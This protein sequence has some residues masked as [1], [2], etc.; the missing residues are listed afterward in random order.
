MTPEISII[1]PIYNV[2]QYLSHCLES[3]W[4]QSYQNFE[5]IMV[6]DGSSD[7]S[8]SIAQG[9]VD[10]DPGFRLV[11]QENK[12]LSAARNTGLQ[13]AKG[14][15]IFYLDADDYLR[16]NALHLL[17]EAAE[18]N[19]ADVVQGNFYYDYPEYLLLN[20]QQ[21]EKEI[22]YNRQE[23]MSALLEHKT[24]L[25]FAWGKLIRAPLAKQFP[26]PEGKYYEDTLWQSQV[27]HHCDKYVALNEPILYYLQRPSAISGSFSIRNLDQL[28]G[29]IER[30]ELLQQ[31]YPESYVY[32]AL[33]LLNRKVVQQRTLLKKLPPTA[34]QKYQKKL[35]EIEKKFDL[36]KRFPLSYNS[37]F[38]KGEKIKTVLRNKFLVTKDWE[39]IPKNIG[40]K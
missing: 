16:E 40:Q 31:N 4:G 19:Q 25:N 13:V 35:Q 20:K 37:L 33:Q 11:S 17:L 8:P 6:N 32:Q 39:K 22:V 24:V 15:Y 9:F 34:F 1:I 18:R 3:V 5:A 14:N 23:A 36:K 10:K 30:I 28:E 38:Q 2:A 21:K 12:G 26:F 29:E 7:S 27:I